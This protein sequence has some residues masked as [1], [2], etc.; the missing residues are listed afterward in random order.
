VN[1][2]RDINYG[3]HTIPQYADGEKSR[4]KANS[5]W[6]SGK[7]PL[8]KDPAFRARRAAKHA[9]HLKNKEARA[10]ANRHGG[11]MGKRK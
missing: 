2:E 9:R 10:E 7:P 4:V 8:L 11:D 1:D 5:L 3:T 6:T